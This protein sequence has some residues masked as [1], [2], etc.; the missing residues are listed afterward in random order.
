MLV[1]DQSNKLYK[2][3]AFKSGASS[4]LFGFNPF[5]TAFASFFLI[6]D[7][8]E[9]FVLIPYNK[10]FNSNSESNTDIRGS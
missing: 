5:K 1:F 7:I 6:L 4:T 9:D 8:T 10:F 2:K 3:A